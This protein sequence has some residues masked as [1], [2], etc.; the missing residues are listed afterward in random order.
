MECC[1]TN[2]RAT[3]RRCGDQSHLNHAF[4]RSGGIPSIEISGG[5][6]ARES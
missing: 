6:A 1:F 3:Y 2:H 4:N 5:R